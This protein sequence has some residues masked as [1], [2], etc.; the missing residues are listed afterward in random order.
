MFYPTG[1]VVYVGEKLISNVTPA[2][3]VRFHLIS[4]R[5]NRRNLPENSGFLGFRY[6]PSSLSANQLDKNETGAE[7]VH[8]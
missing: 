1:V 3:K 2:E 4:I 6:S 5:E 8:K 7:T